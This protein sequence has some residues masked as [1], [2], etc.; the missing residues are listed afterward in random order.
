MSR[1][2]V[3]TDSN[4]QDARKELNA[5]TDPTWPVWK[6]R[7]FGRCCVALSNVGFR[8]IEGATDMKRTQH[9]IAAVVTPGSARMAG[10]L[11]LQYVDARL[12]SAC[13]DID[14]TISERLINGWD[15][16]ALMAEELPL[17]SLC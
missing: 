2:Y 3:R 17:P 7:I 15:N 4:W 6:D 13:Y 5:G 8:K 16:S 10:V 12:G 1:G 9:G 11:R 14:E